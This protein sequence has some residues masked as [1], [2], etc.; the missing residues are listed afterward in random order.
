MLKQHSVRMVSPRLIEHFGH[1]DTVEGHD[2]LATESEPFQ[3]CPEDTVR[4]E[5]TVQ[6][7]DGADSKGLIKNIGKVKAQGLASISHDIERR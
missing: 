1:I 3:V 4:S 6:D 5:M 2:E 7:I